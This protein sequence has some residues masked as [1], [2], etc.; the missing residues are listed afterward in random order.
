MEYF[1]FIYALLTSSRNWNLLLYTPIVITT[2]MSSLLGSDCWAQASNH[3]I[4]R[5]STDN[6]NNGVV[7]SIKW[8]TQVSRFWRSSVPRNGIPRTKFEPATSWSGVNLLNPLSQLIH[9]HYLVN[10]VNH[11]E[12]EYFNFIYTLLTSSRNW[13][14]FLYTPIVITTQTSSQ[15]GSDC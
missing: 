1:N 6:N 4:S 2:Q 12:M 3:R 10:W 13:N 11:V 8:Y 5:I 15:L 7:T 9:G 14:L